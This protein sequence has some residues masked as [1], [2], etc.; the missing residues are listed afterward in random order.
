MK[1]ITTAAGLMLALSAFG[2]G[3]DVEIRGAGVFS[4]RGNQIYREG[5]GGSGSRQG[6]RA[7][8]VYLTVTVKTDTV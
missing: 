3:K 4:V 2:G 5:G 8:G 6:E 1:T 7:S